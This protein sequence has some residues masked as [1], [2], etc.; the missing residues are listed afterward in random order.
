MYRSPP[1]LSQQLVC[2]SF[3][4]QISTLLTVDWM[5]PSG[6]S[7]G[8]MRAPRTSSISPLSKPHRYLAITCSSYVREAGRSQAILL[9][10]ALWGGDNQN[11]Q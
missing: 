4:S 9:Q 1:V 3:D 7:V 5:L 6:L 8:P 11:T 2:D 10:L